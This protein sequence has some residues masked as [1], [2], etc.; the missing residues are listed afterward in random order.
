MRMRTK[1]WARKELAEAQFFIDDATNNLGR[2]HSAF[3]KEQP[4][5]LELR[6]RKRWIYFKISSPKPY[7]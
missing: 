5:H 1:P 2:W 4:I 6:M 3:K 7:N